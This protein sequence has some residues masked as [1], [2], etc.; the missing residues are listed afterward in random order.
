MRRSGPKWWEVGNILPATSPRTRPRQTLKEPPGV[1]RRVPAH[2]GR[3]G[4]DL[5]VPAKFRVQFGAGCLSHAGWTRAWP[6]IRGP[7]G[8]SSRRRSRRSRSRTRPPAVSSASCSRARRRS[9]STGRGGNLLPAFLRESIDLGSEA[10]VVG[11][12]LRETGVPATWATYGQVLD[13]PG[14]LA[15]AFQGLGTERLDDM[16]F[17]GP[18]QADRRRWR[19]DGG[20][21]HPG[22]GGRG[23]VDARACP[24]VVRTATL[25]AVGTERILEATDPDGRLQVLMMGP[26]RQSGRSPPAPVRRIRRGSAP[27]GSSRLADVAPA[28]G[29][30]RGRRAGS[31]TWDCRASSWPMST[32]V[33]A[34]SRGSRTCASTRDAA[35]RRRSCS[36]PW[37]RTS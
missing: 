30:A 25:A 37:T 9:N 7:G 8:M 6:S 12:E 27:G 19:S 33:S 28:A 2:G 1:H 20:W 11:S 3:Q 17:Q 31:S 22:A 13:D 10:V 15:E 36:P 4:T 14:E 21:A 29:S 35:S 5:A 23:P 24:A 26:H 18:L 34:S 32:R 16:R